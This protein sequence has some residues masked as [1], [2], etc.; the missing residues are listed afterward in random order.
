[1]KENQKEILKNKQKRVCAWKK[2]VLQTN[3]KN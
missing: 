3:K 2:S 1:M